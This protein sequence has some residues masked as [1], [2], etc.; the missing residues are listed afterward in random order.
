VVSSSGAVAIGVD[1]FR[2]AMAPIYYLSAAKPE[3]YRTN[4]ST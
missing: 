1:P 3:T 4:W 2:L